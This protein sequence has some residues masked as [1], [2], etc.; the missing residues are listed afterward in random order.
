VNFFEHQEQA[1]G[2]TRKLVLLFGLAIVTLILI[3]TV[4]VVAVFGMVEQ[5][6]RGPVFDRTMLTSDIFLGVAAVVL[7]IVGFGTWFRMQQLRGGGRVVA[8]S[9]GGRLLNVQTRDA[10][11]RKVLNVVEEMAIAAGLPVPPVYLLEDPAINAFAAGFEQRDAVIG[12]TRGSIQ[13]LDREQL[14]GVIAHEFSHIFN[15]DMRLNIRLIGWL[16][17]IM[18]IGMVGYF[19]MR[20]SVY[21]SARG[22]RGN[23]KGSGIVVLGLGLLVIGYSG[24][25]FGNLIKA[26][27]S[28]QRE[29]LADASAVQ[30]TRNPGGI[31]GALKKIGGIGAGITVAETAEISHMLFAQGLQ[32]KFMGLFAT[33]P[34]LEER[35]RR[36]DPRWKG[37]AATIARVSAGTRSASQLVPGTGV[38]QAAVVEATVAA[39][40]ASVGQPDVASVVAAQQQLRGLPA[41]LRDE[42]HS[43]LGSSL[44]MHALIVACA[45]PHTASLQQELLRTQLNEA[46]FQL[47]RQ[48]LQQVYGL[49]REMYLPLVE[50]ALPS[51]AQL[52]PPQ[53]RAFMVLQQQLIRADGN[54]SLFEW[55]LYRI[56]RHSL[57]RRPLPKGR[58]DLQDCHKECVVVLGALAKAG[59]SD[60]NE[61]KLACAAGLDSLGVD[62]SSV[63]LEA[64]DSMNAG[65]I[66]YAL[67]YKLLEK[68]LG[69]LRQ[70]KPLQ[71]PRLL[72]AML[73]CITQDGKVTGAEGELLRAVAAI[74]DCPVPPWPL[75]GTGLQS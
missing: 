3:T 49:V 65:T 73:R 44:L 5:G 21:R 12:I 56:L 34:P 60:A 8:E 40:V 61:A 36:L 14:Q 53:Y 23:D 10:D 43:T 69:R 4:L 50:L 13:Q 66:D 67:D 19:L 63:S 41:T 28:R 55:C 58:L 15:G 1:R 29:F 38:G 30:F 24:T 27:V 26:A 52:S 64:A 46:S 2:T 72:K 9:L 59:H 71:K 39:L 45:D 70:L 31:S 54:L 6:E 18:V 74:L 57:E 37:E 32:Q 11:E 75:A 62:P 47:F 51:L 25:F 35:I 17:G 20:S 22:S 68:A 33:H 48:L 7:C 42:T 16:Y